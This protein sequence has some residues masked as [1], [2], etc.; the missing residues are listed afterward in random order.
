FAEWLGMKVPRTEQNWLSTADIRNLLKL[1]GF[2]ALETH[3]IVLFPKYVPLLSSFLNHFCARLPFLSKLCMT[4][5][6]VARLL[7]RPV[8][9]EQF[10]V[11]VIIPCKN[12]KGNIEDAVRRIPA[13]A[14]RTEIIFCDDQSTD[15]TAAEV[16]RIQLCYPDK[17]IRLENG[18]GVCKSRNVWTGFDAAKGDVL[19][20][21]DAD[22]TTIPEELPY[23]VDVIVSGQ[24]EFVNGSRL[25]YPVPKGAMNGSNMLGNKFFSVA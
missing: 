17:D 11:S 22:L 13:L 14:G 8:L 2:E 18:P 21:L 25:V 4:Q 7:P 5:V 24:A 1:A 10:S 12:E 6:V 16:R 3:R 15:G 9:P 23:F 19:M 20:I